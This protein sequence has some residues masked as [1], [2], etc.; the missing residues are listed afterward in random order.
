MSAVD[1]EIYRVGDVVPHQGAM[2]LLDEILDWDDDS[3]V[4]R[5]K[6][7]DSGIFVD[8][9]G[10]PGWVGI[11]YMA[12]AVAAWAGCVAR[13]DGRLPKIGFLLGSRRYNCSRSIFP[14]GSE[15]T[16]K[17]RC[18]LVGENGLGVF[19]CII[20]TDGEELASANVS[21]FQPADPLTYLEN[22]KND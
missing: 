12:Q 22:E 3:I 1:R 5:L 7:P 16:I 21:V 10:V 8:G 9:G 4:V 11:E 17:A 2:C 19:S 20:E 14:C 6:V 18:E 15:L 13:H